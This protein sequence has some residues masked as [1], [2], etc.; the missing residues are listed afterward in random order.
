MLDRPRQDDNVGNR[1]IETLGF[2][3][4]HSVRHIAETTPFCRDRALL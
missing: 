1:Q 4:Q 2:G 3:G